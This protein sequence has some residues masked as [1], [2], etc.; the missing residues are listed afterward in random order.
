VLNQLTL[1]ELKSPTDNL[2]RHDLEQF[3]A[4][5][6]L[7]RAQQAEVIR[8]DA[9]SAL[10]VAS[11]ITAPFREAAAELGLTFHERE[12]GLW[13]IMGWLFPLWVLETNRLAPSGE[14]VLAFFSRAFL[15]DVQRIIGQWKAAERH[16]I[17]NFIVQ[18]IR[19]FQQMGGPFVM[20]HDT[21]LMDKTLEELEAATIAGMPVEKALK[22]LPREQVEEHVLSEIPI[23]HRLWGLS[24]EEL[25]E[26]R[27]LVDRQLRSDAR[28][29]DPNGG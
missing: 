15:Q 9:L 1:V 23:E 25:E 22:Y 29:E 21:Q 2:E 11:T 27:E 8:R 19:Q 13:E 20:Q 18:Q 14:S 26:L 6:H 17:L 24:R 12:A 28:S 4:Y 3:L 7:F 16:D 10:I 5:I